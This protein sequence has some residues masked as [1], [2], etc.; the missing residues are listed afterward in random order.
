MFFLMQMWHVPVHFFK[1]VLVWQQGRSFVE[2]VRRGSGATNSGGKGARPLRAAQQEGSSGGS[3]R[4]PMAQV[5]RARQSAQEAAV[6]PLATA[7]LTE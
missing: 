4:L 6:W 7:G 2:L 3:R 5:R 1:V